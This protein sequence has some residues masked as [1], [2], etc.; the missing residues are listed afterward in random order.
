[1]NKE[2]KKLKKKKT[3]TQKSNR[4]PVFNEEVVF[5][6]LKKE[7]LEETLILLTVVHSSLTTKETMGTVIIC[8]NSKN[9]EYT[10]WKDMIDGKKSVGWWHLLQPEFNP[11]T[12]MPLFFNN[13][14]NNNSNNYKK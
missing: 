14:N 11:L 9:H 10:H 13:N 12:D 1:M 3:S 5:T 8:S 2:G 6:N 7:S 4:N